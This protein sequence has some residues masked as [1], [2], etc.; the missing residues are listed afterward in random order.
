MA[1]MREVVDDALADV[2]G[3]TQT[4]DATAYLMQAES[5]TSLS[6]SVS[7]AK[8]FSRGLVQI[9]DELLLVDQVDRDSNLLKV[10]GLAGRGVRGSIVMA[11]PVGSLVTMAP[12]VPRSQVMRAVT[13]T[14][15]T[16][17]LFRVETEEFTFRA[18]Q[19]AYDLPSQAN[20][21]LDVSWLPVGPGLNWAPVRRWRHDKYAHQI[22]VADG[23]TSGQPL[24]VTYA[25]DPLPIADPLAEFT[26]SGLE[27]R[28]VDAIRFGAAW[29]ISSFL[30]PSGLTAVR[31][32]AEAMDR[33]KTPGSRLRVAQYYYSMYRQR[34]AEE[35]E[36]LQRR[37]PVRTGGIW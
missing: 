24:R 9:E 2:V 15:S 8:R 35:L 7:D 18:A 4:V 26:D 25:A 21:V 3:Q 11:H 17:G 34:V 5:E 19:S 27:D 12:S 32:E 6:F 23:I 29:R 22:V 36:D 33:G 28:A 20:D 31:A 37:Y 16:C 30:E 10:G 1:T 13:D 14:I